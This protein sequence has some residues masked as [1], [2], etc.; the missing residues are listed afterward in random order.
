[1]PYSL[2]EDIKAAG[3]AGFDGVELWRA[4]L[5]EFLQRGSVQEIIDLLDGYSL[6]AP[7][8][9]AL[10][11]FAWCSETEFKRRLKIAERYLHLASEIGCSSLIV[12]GEDPGDRSPEEVVWA[13]S[14]RL[15]R[16]AELGEEYGVKIA[17][18]WFRDLTTAINI[19]NSAGKE[20]LGLMV[21]T[22]HWYRGDGNLEHIDMIPGDRLILVHINDSE[23]L[24]KEELTDRNRL[25]CGEGVI[26]L[27]EILKRL[28]AKGYGGYLSV[29][30]F[31]EEYWRRDP[32][33]ISREALRTLTRV[34]RRA[35]VL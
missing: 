22:F 6:D 19:V 18:E 9:C 14:T 16:L 24:P 32:A 4:K 11:G 3:E 12:C 30:I 34:M 10:G 1:M 8:I 33:T 27:T 20:Y 21:D 25:Y 28:E 17:L 35:G 2:E 26:P 31:R 29:E 5:D 7:S 13:H 23:D 15:G